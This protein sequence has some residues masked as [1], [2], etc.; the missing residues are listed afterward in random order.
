MKSINTLYSPGR[1]LRSLRAKNAF[2]LIELLIAI[3][4]S[5]ILMTGIIVFVSSSLTPTIKTQK[6][7]EEGNKNNTFESSFRSA[8]A[9][10]NGSGVYATGSSFSDGYLTG[11]FLATR[12]E[13]LPV[14]FVGFKTQTGYCDAFSGTES[15]TGTVMKLAVRQFILPVEQN[16][17]PGYTVSASGNAVFSGTTATG[18]MIIGMGHPGNILDTT[19]GIL[20]ELNRP[21]ALVSSGGYLYVAD[22]MND[23]VLAYNTSNG[24]I[25][26]ILD[27][28]DGISRPTSLYFS[29][30]ILLVASTGNGK[31]FSL[32]DGEWDGFTFFTAFRVAKNF[33]ADSLVFTFSG[34]PLVTSPTVRG[35][36]TFS[37]IISAWSDIVNTG[38]TLQYVF[39]GWSIPSFS[40]LTT[41][42]IQINNI[43][44]APST[45][46]NYP[47]R[48]DFKS[49]ATLNYSDT[50]R[51]FTK[52]DWLLATP[53]GNI[54]RTFSGGFTYPNTITGPTTW[55]G[56]ID[57]QN[58]LGQNPPGSEVLSNL[59]IKSFD[60]SISGKILTIKYIEYTFYDCILGKHRTQERVRKILL[61]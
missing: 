7:L 59:P 41:Y 4:I 31:I 43:A 24:T 15:E 22:T 37:G 6:T 36:F 42:G 34:I 33:S 26:Q 13:N 38:S 55:S 32:Q 53:T 14:T 61:P 16:N 25:T 28:I 10:I 39:S 1:V 9:N 11:I 40:T 52:G 29:G 47:V 49:G 44:P 46:G 5:A 57:W 48:I 54:L 20:T 35:S 17:A 27:R 3:S 58:V 23:R 30:S 2:T 19:S 45:A 56:T 18:V 21:S 8:F 50:F 60:Y 51:Y 12:G